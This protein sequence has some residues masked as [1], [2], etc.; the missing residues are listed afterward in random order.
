MEK[1]NTFSVEEKKAEKENIWKRK[2]YFFAEEKTI[3]GEGK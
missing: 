2:I 3:I 1:E